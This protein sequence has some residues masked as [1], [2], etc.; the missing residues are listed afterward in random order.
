M[1]TTIPDLTFRDY[2]LHLEAEVS[3]APSFVPHT[4]D[5]CTKL[6]IKCPSLARDPSAINCHVEGLSLELIYLGAAGGCPLYTEW[7]QHPDWDN[8]NEASNWRFTFRISHRSTFMDATGQL[9]K[10]GD[11]T[12][13]ETL[14][15]ALDDDGVEF[16]DFTPRYSVSLGEGEHISGASA[17]CSV[18]C[19]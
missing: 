10:Q 17:T 4:C 1:E 14:L 19:T 3:Q 15:R 16:F 8:F 9:V 2:S 5:Y 18:N 11:D 13:F 12:G 7:L 6:L